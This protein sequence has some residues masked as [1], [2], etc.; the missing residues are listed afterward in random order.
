MGKM[1]SRLL[2][3]V[4]LAYGGIAALLFFSQEKL[5]YYPQIGREIQPRNGS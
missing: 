4:V 5:T 2:T 3:L 1:L